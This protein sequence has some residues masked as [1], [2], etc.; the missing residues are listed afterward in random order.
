M[1]A[2]VPD[3]RYQLWPNASHALPAEIPDEVNACI[4]QFVIENRTGV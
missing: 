2:V 3:W 1:Q 4:R